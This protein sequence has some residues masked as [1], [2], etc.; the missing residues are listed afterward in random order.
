MIGRRGFIGVLMGAPAMASSAIQ[1][2]AEVAQASPPIGY[3]GPTPP[4]V[5]PLAVQARRLS[6]EVFRAMDEESLGYVPMPPDIE[7]MKSWSSSFK[8]DQARMRA[9]QALRERHSLQDDIDAIM[10]DDVPPAKAV[11]RLQAILKR[12]RGRGFLTSG[13]RL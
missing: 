13:V 8:A 5:D 2:V 9:R 6:K 10:D 12:I 11:F 3:P 7:G 1:S 4:Q